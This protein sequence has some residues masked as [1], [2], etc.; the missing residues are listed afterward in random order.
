MWSREPR[1]VSRSVTVSG[2]H[3]RIPAVFGRQDRAR[4]G[5]FAEAAIVKFASV[6]PVG[7]RI[8]KGSPGCVCMGRE[9]RARRRMIW[10]IMKQRAVD[11]AKGFVCDDIQSTNW[12]ESKNLSH[13]ATLWNIYMYYHS[14]KWSCSYYNNFLDMK[15]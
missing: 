11:I 5:N 3:I 8:A 4:S 7:V 14:K 2:V 1:E 13:N 12:G 9:R 6:Q 10:P 15:N